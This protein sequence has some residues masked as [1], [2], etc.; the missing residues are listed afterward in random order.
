MKTL[1]ILVG[2]PGSGKSTWAKKNVNDN[3]VIISSDEIRKELFGFEDQTHQDKV[4]S[5]MHK[6]VKDY[7]MKG[8]SI[9]YDATNIS[10]KRRVALAQEMRKHFDKII[11]VVF[12][13]PIKELLNRNITRQERHLPEDKL[14]QMI[15]TIEIPTIYEY[16]YDDIKYIY[17]GVEE[18]YDFTLEDLMDYDQHNKHH[19]EPLG[20]HIERVSNA[21]KGN[22]YAYAAAVYHDIGKPFCKTVDEEGYF[23][24]IGHASVSMYMYATDILRKEKNLLEEEH[25]IILMLI[26]MHDWIFN[27]SH[28]F[29]EMRY[30]YDKK[31]IGLPDK[32]WD[33][34][35]MLTKADR[36]RP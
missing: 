35:R 30:H 32:F 5:T 34:L 25:Q 3:T 29:E 10:R 13:C 9:I 31:Y 21:C 17:T 4:F 1:Y 18:V 12:V 33:S 26:L 2:I 19:S 23:H 28:N 36:L 6:R 15:K 8:Y 20:R 24:F 22:D 16:K 7:A 27:F 11:P 14:R